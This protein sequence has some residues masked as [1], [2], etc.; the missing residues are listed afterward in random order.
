M[1]PP[2][3]KKPYSI[4]L[5]GLVGVK[6]HYTLIDFLLHGNGTK[7]IVFLIEEVK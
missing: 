5:R 7:E 3:K 6:W 2:R 1:W 4:W